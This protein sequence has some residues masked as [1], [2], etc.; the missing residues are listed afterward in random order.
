MTELVSASRMSKTG[1]ARRSSPSSALMTT[2][3]EDDSENESG[4]C[5]GVGTSADNDDETIALR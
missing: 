2:H 5:G 4:G 3:V 1:G